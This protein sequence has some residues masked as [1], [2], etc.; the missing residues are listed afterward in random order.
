MPTVRIIAAVIALL[1]GLTSVGA[2][3]A[4]TAPLPTPRQ[5]ITEIEGM[6]DANYVIVDMRPALKA[7]LEKSLAAG[8]YAG[9]D[10]RSLS[11]SI[12]D[13]LR[14]VTHDKHLGVRFDPETASHLSDG[15]GRPA[16]A[17][18]AYLAKQD[19]AQNFG[20]TQLRILDG[21]VRVMTYDGFMWD[22]AASATAIDNAM[23]FLR[24]GD[25][26][27]IDI[28]H[29][30]GGSP[31]AS[32]YLAS[33]FVEPG[34]KLVTFHL[35]NDPPTISRSV[36]VHGQR[37]TGIPV[38]VL[39]SGHTASAAEEFSSHVAR[40]KFATLVGETTAG[41]AHRNEIY[42]LPG[43]YLISISIGQPELPD[44]GNWEGKGVIP[45]IAAASDRALDVAHA[46]A[47]GALAAKASPEERKRY[48]RLRAGAAARA[49]PAIPA[50]SLERYV[51][52]YG[53]ATI[54]VE[55][56]HLIA[57]SFPGNKVRLLPL[58]PDLFAAD[59]DPTVQM[60]FTVEN[61]QTTAMQIDSLDAPPTSA[62]KG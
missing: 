18:L 30:G 41:A 27:I 15:N 42:P 47:L 20:V 53:R 3:A 7:A 58:T 37:L 1:S 13:D 49:A 19:R 55:G 31:D 51:G 59:I 39:T 29:N 9:A 34:E 46:A 54:T 38:Y 11:E 5:L 40:L 57:S 12:T 25:A 6:I 2:M 14:A 16:P 44:G 48:E 60:R 61:G 22:G 52:R 33:Y 8:R 26:A 28:R 10:P 4:E 36:K 50:L 35:R 62:P 21:G 56:D 17:T 32:A 23:E 45:Q 24:G 43:G